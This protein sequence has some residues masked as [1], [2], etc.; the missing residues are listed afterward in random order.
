MKNKLAKLHAQG[1]QGVLVLV[2]LALSSGCGGEAPHEVIDVSAVPEGTVSFVKDVAPIIVK[3][4]GACHVSDAK[5]DL[6][7]GNYSRLMQGTLANGAVII[8]GVP[9]RSSFITLVEEG[10]MPKKGG[11]LKASDQSKLRIWVQEGAFFDGG[12]QGQD[13]E[14]LTGLEVQ[15]LPAE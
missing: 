15:P 6:S 2:L 14:S 3:H 12:S 8:P 7:L 1:L 9:D 5:G 10:E 13:L 11:P 4:C